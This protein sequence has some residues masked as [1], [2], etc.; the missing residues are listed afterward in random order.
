M[1]FTKFMI[2]IYFQFVGLCVTFSIMFGAGSS[3]V[4]TPSVVILGHY[5]N[6]YHGIVNGFVT[7]GSSLFGAALPHLLKFLF[8]KLGVS[9][10]LK[11]VCTLKITA[12]KRQIM[13]TNITGVFLHILDSQHT[14]SY[15]WPDFYINASICDL[16]ASIQDNSEF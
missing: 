16:Q 9:T 4:Y 2:S 5:F 13:T 3:L 10:S 1:F 6:R 15:C 8:S 14:S 12:L 7:T 11:M